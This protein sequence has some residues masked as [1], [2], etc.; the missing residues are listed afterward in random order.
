MRVRKLFEVLKQTL[1]EGII[2]FA[3]DISLELLLAEQSNN[4][5]KEL[6]EVLHF[7]L[8]RINAVKV[9]NLWVKLSNKKLSNRI[10]CMRISCFLSF[11]TVGVD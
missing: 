2:F 4:E 1:V 5:A 8:V 3:D 10:D 6:I 11:I 9:S 7:F